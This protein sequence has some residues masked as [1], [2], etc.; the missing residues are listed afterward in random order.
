MG[1]LGL[2]HGMVGCARGQVALGTPLAAPEL[3]ALPQTTGTA[4]MPVSGTR[5][6]HT[7]VTALFAGGVS[8]QLALA[9]DA[10]GTTWSG[11][12]QLAEGLN[13]FVLVAQDAAGNTQRSHS[14]SITYIAAIPGAPAV[15]NSALGLVYLYT[16]AGSTPM[17]TGDKEPTGDIALNGV[18]AVPADGNTRWQVALQ[19]LQDNVPLNL[20]LTSTNTVGHTSVPTT[21]QVHTTSLPPLQLEAYLSPTRQSPLLLQGQNP[22]DTAVHVLWQGQPADDQL[23][24]LDTTHF[25]FNAD[26]AATGVHDGNVVAAFYPVKDGVRG[27]FTLATI[28]YDTVAPAAPSIEQP[29][30][31]ATA[32]PYVLPSADSPASL[33]LVGSLHDAWAHLCIGL[34]DATGCSITAPA[35]AQFSVHV[36]LNPGHNAVT[37]RAVDAAGNASSSTTTDVYVPVAPS[38][39][40]QS[41]NAYAYVQGDSIVV[42]G[43]IAL[44]PED[45]AVARHAPELGLAAVQVCLGAGACQSAELEG[46][47]FSAVVPLTG[48]PSGAQQIT[49]QAVNALGVS[50][51][52][53]IGGTAPPPGVTP[54]TPSFSAAPFYYATQ[55]PTWLNGAEG[56]ILAARVP[57]MAVDATGTVHVVWEDY[58]TNNGGSCVV[59]PTGSVG[60]DIFYTTRSASGVWASSIRT[61][62]FTD[63][64]DGQSREPTIAV[65]QAGLVHVAWSDN[66]LATGSM[67][68]TYGIFHRTIDP[69]TGAL[70]AIDQVAGRDGHCA[71]QPHLAANTYGHGP[72]V[73]LTWQ[74]E[75]TQANGAVRNDI[76]YAAW[77]GNLPVQPNQTA[78]AWSQPLQLTRDSNATL[79]QRPQV[80][81]GPDQHV[82]IAW[83][84]CQGPACLSSAARQDVFVVDVADPNT[85]DT[86]G[87]VTVTDSP[88]DR[89]GL[90]PRLFIA[91]DNTRYIVWQGRSETGGANPAIAQIF[92]R[93]YRGRSPDVRAPAAV[94][95][96][97]GQTLPARVPTA[98]LGRDGTFAIAWSQRIPGT[99]RASQI[100]LRQGHLDRGLAGGATQLGPRSDIVVH[101]DAVVDPSD[102]RLTH[103][104]WDNVAAFAD[105]AAASNSIT[106]PAHLGAWYL[107]Q[108]GP[109]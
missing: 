35:G 33:L 49:V 27:P 84:G 95:L 31:F 16:P 106:A 1:T 28:A 45:G 76:Y 80:A 67:R 70:S 66:G 40:L 98:D 37:V 2:A 69:G 79:A 65:D 89:G 29:A 10:H 23:R 32:A 18:Q 78:G 42:A 62:S 99:Q 12:L 36:P 5:A 34:D 83:H 51:M 43:R 41:P 48:L 47:T 107:K 91:P 61:L 64:Q 90:M 55:T 44:T 108:P 3:D 30:A 82:S 72:G 22:A 104:A 20:T 92:M 24:T 88:A 25:T 63:T 86:L 103:L 74:R 73:H 109:N 15:D 94:W 105:S 46:N 19:P 102:P 96:S 75:K 21:L 9:G 50:Y 6:A 7:S 93:Q 39:I 54:G 57:R 26:L 38:A 81:M 87:P 53:R 100:M 58:C 56:A 59:S 13:Q 14:Y 71:K 101:I 60:P 85:I 77:Q 52:A 4:N 97:A 68:N 8:Q 17:L 11:T